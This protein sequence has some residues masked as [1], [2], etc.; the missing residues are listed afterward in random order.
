MCQTVF[1]EK[2][3]SSVI[4]KIQLKIIVVSYRFVMGTRGKVAR[5]LFAKVNFSTDVDT[6]FGVR[7][8]ST[9]GLSKINVEPV[10]VYT[11]QHAKAQV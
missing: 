4:N 1:K 11:S 10:S 6:I 5:S 3:A 7:H 8:D 9:C 2:P